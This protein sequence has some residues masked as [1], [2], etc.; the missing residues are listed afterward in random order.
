LILPRLSVRGASNDVAQWSLLLSSGSVDAMVC[1][2]AFDRHASSTDAHIQQTLGDLQLGPSPWPYWTAASAAAASTGAA[3]GA[4]ASA[5]AATKMAGRKRGRAEA[6]QTDS[7][8]AESQGELHLAV[9]NATPQ[10]AH[11]ARL[12][13]W[14]V[15][16][17]TSSYPVL[18]AALNAATAAEASAATAASSA[19]AVPTALGLRAAMAK[20]HL[21]LLHLR[22][23]PSAV[24]AQRAYGL[25]RSLAAI[26]GATPAS[27]HVIAARLRM[28]GVAAL[29]RAGMVTEALQASAAAATAFPWSA[30]VALC[31]AALLHL[32]HQAAEGASA[33][34]GGSSTKSRR[35][36]ST[37]LVLS[38]AQLLG[39]KQQLSA[40]P[41]PLAV[42]RE[43]RK[44]IWPAANTLRSWEASLEAAAFAAGATVD[45]HAAAKELQA[46]LLAGLSVASESAL[47][48]HY[49]S[50]CRNAGQTA[51]FA[52]YQ[53]ALAPSAPAEVHVEAI[54]TLMATATAGASGNAQARMSAHTAQL[55][56]K[57]VEAAV[58]VHGNTSAEL[59][60]AYHKLE[61]AAGSGASSSG[62]DLVSAVYARAQRSLQPD[63]RAR[64]TEAVVRGE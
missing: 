28:L 17:F 31:R 6:E 22:F 40:R 49:L 60:F 20:F 1:N 7:T 21:R 64:F 41:T 19:T 24:E 34:S 33:S 57:L 15:S 10:S 5:S 9:D 63:A 25:L 29:L 54:N 23:A 45:L 53:A 58:S 14:A 32:L 12:H 38:S 43:A 47:R 18:E 62:I 2:A 59:W 16:G 3:S 4:S 35:Q 27:K 36:A 13:A 8:S 39:W 61:R 55:L 44:H 48:A 26:C 51:T 11:E 30:E 37:D 46:G 42:L 56:R 50:L 52:D